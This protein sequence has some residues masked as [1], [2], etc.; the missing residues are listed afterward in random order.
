MAGFNACAELAEPAQVVGVAPGDI[1]D[2]PLLFA[3][4]EC[5]EQ[6]TA[7]RLTG[8]QSRW[9]T[10]HN[11]SRF[12]HGDEIVDVVFADERKEAWVY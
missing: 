7:A 6:S 9:N 2:G 1:L 11:P 4:P 12:N 5:S 8:R 3:A 10:V